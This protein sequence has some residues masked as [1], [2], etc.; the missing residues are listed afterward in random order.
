VSSEIALNVSGAQAVDERHAEAREAGSRG[1]SRAEVT[2]FL[3]LALVR[4]PVLDRDVKCDNDT[5]CTWI[6]GF[7]NS[8]VRSDEHARQHFRHA[9][10]C[11]CPTDAS[12][13]L[14]RE[15]L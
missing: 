10:A 2:H 12:P 7:V 15:Y 1:A 5:L 14:A 11:P 3:L 13:K 9:K 6:V 4:A 8:W